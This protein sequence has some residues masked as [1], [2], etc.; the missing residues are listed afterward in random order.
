VT[1]R[2]GKEIKPWKRVPSQIRYDWDAE[3][4]KFTLKWNLPFTTGDPTHLTY[5][6]YTFPHGF[7]E[8][9][10]KLDQLEMQ[11]VRKNVYVHRETVCYSLEGRKMEMVTISS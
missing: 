6:A 5:I 3:E 10:Q 9:G 4:E 11:A 7:I 2:N 8:M 1:D